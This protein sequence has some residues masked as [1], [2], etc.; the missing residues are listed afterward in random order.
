M[1]IWYD[2]VVRDMTPQEEADYIEAREHAASPDEV[3]PEEI[4]NIL[5]GGAT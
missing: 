2:G 5:L 3:P 1:K 4:M